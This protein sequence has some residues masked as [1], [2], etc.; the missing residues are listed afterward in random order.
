MILTGIDERY[1]V[2]VIDY[3]PRLPRPKRKV[4]FIINYGEIL[5]IVSIRTELFDDLNSK[6]VSW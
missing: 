1:I 3:M 5:P 2:K 6:V 4:N